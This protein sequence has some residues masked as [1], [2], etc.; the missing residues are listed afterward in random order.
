MN[1]IIHAILFLML[2]ISFSHAGKVLIVVDGNYYYF[3]PNGRTLVTQYANL[4]KSIDGDSVKLDTTFQT[5]PNYQNYIQVSELWMR[6]VDEYNADTTIEGAVLIGDLPIPIFLQ[7]SDAKFVP[8]DYPYMDIRDKS[9]GRNRLYTLPL[10]PIAGN[11]NGLW[12]LEGDTISSQ[13]PTYLTYFRWSGGTYRGDR[14]ADIWVSRIYSGK[15]RTLRDNGAGWN[16]RLNEYQIIDRYLQRVISR[17]TAIAEV[18]PRKLAIGSGYEWDSISSLNQLKA[19]F[20]VQ[21]LNDTRY[22]PYPHV[23]P[24]NY[25][26]QLQS[27]PY[28]G[29]TY[30]AS[31]GQRFSNDCRIENIYPE[32]AGDT[33]G[34][35]WICMYNHSNPYNHAW[36]GSHNNP[37]GAFGR[38][39]SVHASQPWRYMENGGYS[40]DGCTPDY[41]VTYTSDCVNQDIFDGV[42]RT[43]IMFNPQLIYRFQNQDTGRYTVQ[44]H[45]PPWW[46]NSALSKIDVHV[47]LSNGGYFTTSTDTDRYLRIPVARI[48]PGNDWA[49]LWPT[50]NNPWEKINS[51]SAT[52]EVVVEI[53][54]VDMYDNGGL[55]KIVIGDA[56]RLER[57]RFLGQPLPTL[58]WTYQDNPSDMHRMVDQ[59]SRT[60]R[61]FTSMQDDGGKSKAKFFVFNACQINNFLAPNNLGNTYAMGDN[62]LISIG[63]PTTCYPTYYYYMLAEL[64]QGV[65]FG[66][67]YLHFL[68]SRDGFP[69]IGGTSIALLGAGTLKA[70]AYKPYLDY[71]SDHTFTGTVTTRQAFWVKNNAV[72]Q[73][74]TVLYNSSV[75]EQKIY[76]G[77]EIRLTAE[78]RIAAGC[79]AHFK[80]DPRLKQ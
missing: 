43:D 29:V 23:T 49:Q 58:S 27:G 15:L 42:N 30:G 37:E 9:N 1:R 74:L 61:A 26:A 33:R 19:Y 68:N 13:D 59:S 48:Q 7:G 4:V 55:N 28:G 76:A 57:A 52:C 38:F 44:L 70:L 24:N 40:Q 47:H 62:G 2:C 22:I 39:S 69:N 16:N 31:G 73:N 14:I 51:S 8:I 67:A 25:Q 45:I 56:V 64:Q 77:N 72:L 35:E 18:P 71:S 20:E 12:S 10:T 50:L 66:T 34:F 80:I 21:G 32:Y 17:M 11:P 53:Y 63:R 75:P 3:S 60:F 65:N 79:E 41:F 5:D 6:L 46:D 78:T 54:P 36:N